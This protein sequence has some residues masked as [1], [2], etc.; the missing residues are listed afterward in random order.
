M[1]GTAKKEV[2]RMI[3][4]AERFMPDRFQM[5]LPYLK[6]AEQKLIGLQEKCGKL[7]EEEFA[8]LRKKNGD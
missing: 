6:D 4:W 2:R 8:A 3:E 1:I 5:T 7:A